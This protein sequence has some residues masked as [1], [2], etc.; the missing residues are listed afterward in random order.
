VR[1]R[2]ESVRKTYRRRNGIEVEALAGIDL[3]VDASEFVCILGPSGCG[4]STLLLIAAGL[5]PPT[6]GRVVF[7]GTPAGHPRTA[8]VFQEFALFPWRTV[9]H[10][11]AFGLEVRGVRRAERVERALAWIRQVGLA[12]FEDRYPHELSGGMRQ[13]VGIARALC[14]DPAVLLMDE[15]LSALD[16][17]T[18]QLLQVDI[19]ALWERSRK[20]VLYVTHNIQ[21]AVFLADRVV[22]LSRRPG[23]VREILYVPFGRPRTEDLLADPEFARFCHRIWTSLRDEAQAA[24][25]EADGG[26]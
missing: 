7:E 23:R 10:N 9:L 13:R 24:M 20:T 6:A 1:V 18:R 19:L 17:Q 15:P 26:S 4:K 12:G 2:F 21:E 14:V 8:M 25:Q 5:V 11:V 16:A 3:V 22:V